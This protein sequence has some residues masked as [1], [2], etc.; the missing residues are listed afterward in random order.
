[1]LDRSLKEPFTLLNADFI[2]LDQ[3]KNRITH[4]PDKTD[5][6]SDELMNQLTNEINKTKKVNQEKYLNFKL[7]GTEYIAIIKPVSDKN[8][9]GL[10]WI[11]IYSNIKQI[12]QLQLV[13]NI[14]LLLML[15]FKKLIILLQQH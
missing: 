2:L 12:N 14:I 1:M 15:I 7:S 4:F 5:S 13:I 11:I 9:F 3:N 6:A 8:S 10:G